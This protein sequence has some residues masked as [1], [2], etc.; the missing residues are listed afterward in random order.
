MLLTGNDD[1][2]YPDQIRVKEGIS[3]ILKFSSKGTV[4]VIISCK[5][6]FF[7]PHVVD[8]STLFVSNLRVLNIR[9]V[10]ML[11]VLNVGTVSTLCVLNVGTVPTLCI[12]NVGTVPTLCVCY[13]GTVPTFSHFCKKKQCQSPFKLASQVLVKKKNDI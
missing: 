3:P 13:V 9:T 2:T 12:L 5:L 8:K 11:C 10:P 1:S 6:C 7:T 4:P